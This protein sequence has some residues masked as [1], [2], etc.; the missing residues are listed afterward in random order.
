[1]TPVPFEGQN[2]VFGANQSQYNPLPAYQDE[3]GHVVTCWEMTESEKA[4][5][6]LTG[7][8]FILISTFNQPLQPILPTVVNPMRNDNHGGDF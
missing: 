6:I 2:R 4:E 5:F 8:L 1:M 3:T 7:R